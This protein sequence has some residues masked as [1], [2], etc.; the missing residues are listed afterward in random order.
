MEDESGLNEYLSI[1]HHSF[2]VYLS[3][4]ILRIEGGC[5]FSKYIGVQ[6]LPSRGSEA[7]LKPIDSDANMKPVDD[8]DDFEDGGIIFIHI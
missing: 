7:R 8:E 4:A 3:M 5:N 2:D 1:V 6:K